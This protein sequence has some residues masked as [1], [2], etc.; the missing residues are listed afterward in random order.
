MSHSSSRK[1]IAAVFLIVLCT[2]PVVSALYIQHRG[3]FDPLPIGQKIPSIDGLSS[4]AGVVVQDSLARKKSLLLFFT[5]ACGHCRTE[6]SNLNKLRLK[7]QQ[8]LDIIAVSLDNRQAT[9]ALEEELK[10]DIPI[11]IADNRKVKD[12]FK[13]TILPVLYYIDESRILRKHSRGEHSLAFDED[14]I[15]EFIN[16]GRGR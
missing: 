8:E 3:I 7:Y 15:R 2:V 13:L 12:D 9:M 14:L 16:T 1:S 11:L 4:R 10:L 5:T 6:I